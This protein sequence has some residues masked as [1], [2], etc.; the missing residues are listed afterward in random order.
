MIKAIEDPL[1]PLSEIYKPDVRQA[2]FAG[3]LWDIH[4]VLR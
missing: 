1:K 2:N 4:S 3:D